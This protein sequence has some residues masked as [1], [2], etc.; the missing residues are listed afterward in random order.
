MNHIILGAGSV[1]TRL[2][3]LLADRGIPVRLISR[4][5]RGPDDPRVERIALDAADGPALRAAT[6]GTEVIYN[7][8]NAPYDQWDDMWPPIN[9]ALISAAAASGAVLVNTGNLYGYGHVSGPIT[10]DLPLT[11]TTRKGAL[12]ARMWQQC[13]AAHQA[14]DICTVEVRGSDYIGDAGDQEMFGD[15]LFDAIRAG[16]RYTTIGGLDQPH[17]WTYTGDVVRTLAAVAERPDTWGRA[18]HVPSNPPKSQR[19]VV[20]DLARA[21]GVPVPKMSTLPRPLLRIVGRFNPTILELDEML[22][23]FTAPFVLDARE[24]EQVLGLSA[25]GWSEVLADTVSRN[26]AVSPLP[27]SR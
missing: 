15:R 6:T 14:G 16:K 8:L 20:S 22:Y 21:A 10:P 17:T 25:T 24:T 2:S 18:W 27:V 4:S 13:L 26:A 7:C 11:A 1:G 5:G 23:E 9:E 12:R 3:L 19:Q